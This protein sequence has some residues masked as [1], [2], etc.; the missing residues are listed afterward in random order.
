MGKHYCSALKQLIVDSRKNEG[1]SF[2]ALVEKFK[3]PRSTVRD[4]VKKFETTG[5]VE[6]VAHSNNRKT[7]KVDTVAV[8]LGNVFQRKK[9][10]CLIIRKYVLS[11][12]DSLSFFERLFIFIEASIYSIGKL[13]SY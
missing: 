7:T 8:R 13:T 3:V 10:I 5:S 1:L 12:Q 4:L 6:N 2:S 11:R 9:Y